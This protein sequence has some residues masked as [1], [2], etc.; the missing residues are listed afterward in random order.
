MLKA[1]FTLSKVIIITHFLKGYNL[2]IIYSGL[3]Y[4]EMLAVID[5]TMDYKICAFRG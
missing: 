5:G 1:R 4:Y 3:C 2:C